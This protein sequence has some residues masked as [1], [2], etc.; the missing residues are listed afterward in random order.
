VNE[1]FSINELDKK[2]LNLLLK[3]S[4]QSYRTLA[5]KLGVSI[6]T[7]LKHVK[8]LEKLGIVK[9]YTCSLDYEKLG[10]DILVIIEIRI[11][12]GKLI[13]VERKIA[14]H[15]NVYAVYDHT[16]AFDATLIARFKNRRALDNFVKLIQSYDFVERTKTKLVLN[17]IKEENNIL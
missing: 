8:N 3:N 17:T 1:G 15:R 11:A 14:T 10:Y 2:I 7:V 16:G 12:K 4:R 6:T 5:K 9:K 13:E